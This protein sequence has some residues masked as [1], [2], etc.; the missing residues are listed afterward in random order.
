MPTPAERLALLL[1][2]HGESLRGAAELCGLDHTTLM[3]VKRGETE[4][5]GTLAKIAE[6]F[7]VP[8][9]W[10]RGE[11]HLAMDFTCAVLTCPLEERVLFLWDGE[12]RIA[13]ALGFLRQYDPN[14]YTLARLGELIQLPECRVAAILN[15]GSGLLEGANV[16]NFISESGLPA[17]WFQTGLVGRE[18][19]EELLVGLAAHVLTNLTQAYGVEITRDELWEA[20]NALV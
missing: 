9:S 15:Q 14:R 2:V 11:P 4:G 6:G 7:R 16:E 10:M 8:I 18:N 3:R 13:H 20:A 5:P 12:R 19:E 17:K 1:E